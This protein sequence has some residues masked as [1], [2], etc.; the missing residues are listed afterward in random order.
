MDEDEEIDIEEQKMTEGITTSVITALKWVPRSFCM[1][2]PLTFELN[3]QERLEMIHATPNDDMNVEENVLTAQLMDMELNEDAMQ[4][5]DNGED[6]SDLGSDVEDHILKPNDQILLAASVEEDQANLEIHVYDEENASFYLH[7]DIALPSYALAIEWIGV[8]GSELG[9]SETS[10]QNY[11]AVG[12][13]DPAIEVWNLDVVDALEPNCK[14]EGH[15]D[16]VLGLS[17]N[18]KQTNL[19]ASASAD[20]QVRLWDLNQTTSVR[21]FSIHEN[22]VQ[23]VAWN[24]AEESILL[25]ASFD[26]TVA[27]F[28]CRN[29]EK[30]ARFKLDS[31]VECITWDI[32]QPARFGASCE[33]GQ[34]AF[35][36]VRNQTFPLLLFQAHDKECSSL[37]GNEWVSGLFIT[38]SSVCFLFL[39]FFLKILTFFI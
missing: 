7:H 9:W 38:A 35:F 23:Q 2:R 22:K 30:I 31:D 34:V 37:C 1:N 6:V 13:F 28:D 25:S 12:G 3:K 33:N 21:E 20:K 29:P 19:M 39:I 14:L 4:R 26:Q 17:W 8:P 5:K 32:H 16:A 24:P 36:D 10:S 11:A 18:K 15:K 27:L